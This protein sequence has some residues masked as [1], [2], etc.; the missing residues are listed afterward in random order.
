MIGECLGGV[1]QPR[2]VLGGV[3]A[4]ALP[5]ALQLWIR[6]P[7]VLESLSPGLAGAGDWWNRKLRV[8]RSRM[9][10]Q[11]TYLSSDGHDHDRAEN[12]AHA[13]ALIEHDRVH[14]YTCLLSRRWNIQV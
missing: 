14:H 13:R 1:W 2:G 9:R 7:G 10:I 4:L 6:Q 3:P 5:P 11:I 12:L 8:V